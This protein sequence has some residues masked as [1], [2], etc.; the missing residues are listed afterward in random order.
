MLVPSE[1]NKTLLF[2]V[3]CRSR[4]ISTLLVVKRP[5]QG[6]VK[7]SA[8]AGLLLSIMVKIM[9]EKIRSR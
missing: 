2:C 5:E 6:K 8:V 3:A 4:A 9:A 1:P 7:T